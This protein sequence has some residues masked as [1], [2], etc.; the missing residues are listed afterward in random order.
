MTREE[1]IFYEG[2]QHTSKIIECISSLI[3][4]NY[5]QLPMLPIFLFPTHNIY[6]K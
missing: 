1:P 2:H 3:C 4:K 5:I 6:F